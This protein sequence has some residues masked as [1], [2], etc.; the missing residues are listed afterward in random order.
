MLLSL[1]RP[2]RSYSTVP[3]IQTD[4]QIFSTRAKHLA[5]KYSDRLRSL[6]DAHSPR[7]PSV[8]PAS[9]GLLRSRILFY[10]ACLLLHNNYVHVSHS[11]L[12][13]LPRKTVDRRTEGHTHAH[14]HT[15]RQTAITLAAHARRR[16]LIIS[17][18]MAAFHL[19][20]F[21][22]PGHQSGILLPRQ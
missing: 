12:P 3:S 5:S 1:H 2:S 22:V 20:L 21:R 15:H 16:G 4:Q 9:P 8:S 17:S 19:V 13:R 14:T 18:K 10:H 7:Q 11:E 6:F